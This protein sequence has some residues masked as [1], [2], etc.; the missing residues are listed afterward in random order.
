VPACKS[1]DVFTSIV[2]TDI[3]TAKHPVCRP[4]MMRKWNQDTTRGGFRNRNSPQKVSDRGHAL[5]NNKGSDL[6][7]MLRLASLLVF[8]DSKPPTR[9]HKRHLAMNARRGATTITVT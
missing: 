5:R 8:T 2:A 6:H 9:L 3:N 1:R 4:M 7:K